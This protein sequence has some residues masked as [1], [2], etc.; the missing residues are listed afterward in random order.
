M[1]KDN[2][3]HFVDLGSKQK[4]LERNEKARIDQWAG[5]AKSQAHA[6]HDRLQQ[7]WDRIDQ[8]HPRGS[9]SA[10]P[11]HSDKKGSNRPL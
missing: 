9:E 11:R 8:H 5:R 3:Q 1:K 7:A 10:T 4:E 6:A 2:K